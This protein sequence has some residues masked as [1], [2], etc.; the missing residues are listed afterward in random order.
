MELLI[1]GLILVALMIYASTRI[2]RSAALAYEAES[3]ETDD[4]R[5][6]KPEGFLNVIGGDPTFVF[7]AYS[8]DFGTDLAEQFRLATATVAARNDTS[9]NDAANEILDSGGNVTDDHHYTTGDAAYRVIKLRVSET[10]VEFFAFSK[11]AARGDKVFV[12]TIKSIAETTP[13]FLRNI[14]E[15]LDSFELK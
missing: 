5:L 7:E 11:L 13:E 4:F 15:M 8:K 14:E 1:P 3:I 10:G 9:I 6:Q 2:K 12:F